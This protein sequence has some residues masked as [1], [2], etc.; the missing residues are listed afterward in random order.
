[1]N[2][3]VTESPVDVRDDFEIDMQVAAQARVPVLISGS[4]RRAMVLAKAIAGR[5][6]RPD[7]DIQILSCD[8]ADC[9]ADLGA[10][11][12]TSAS[13]ATP[14]PR[15]SIVMLREVHALTQT[16]QSALRRLMTGKSLE[17]PQVFASSSV[18]LYQ[19]VKE[20]LFDPELFYCLNVVHIVTSE[21]QY[22]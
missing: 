12:N 1:M 22:E 10:V 2:R 6:S 5:T 15:I 19:R 14:V 21:A 8:A 13:E 9:G 11:F 3:D 4:P 17:A 7:G 16:G 20:G 18:S